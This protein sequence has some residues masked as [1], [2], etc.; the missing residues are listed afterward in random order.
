RRLTI[1]DL[2]SGIGTWSEVLAE[3]FGAQVIG[4]EPSARMRAVAAQEHM[5]P[6]VRYAEG[7]GERI[8]LADSS[9]DAA[10]LSYVIHHVAD[11]DACAAE[12]R[13]VLRAGAWVL[14]RGALR[15]SLASAP[16]WRF[17]PTARAIAERQFP[18]VGEV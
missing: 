11:R 10:L 3:A 1:L 14:V 9:C 5:H 18:S 6:R 7:A 2:G 13:R 15:D 8:P 12:L 16:H 4:I 17:F